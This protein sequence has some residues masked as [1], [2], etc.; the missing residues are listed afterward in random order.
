MKKLS[1][2]RL[3]EV[4]DLLADR[5]SCRNFS[6]EEIPEELLERL[7]QIGT[8]APSGGNLQSYTI[9]AVRDKEKKKL[10]SKALGQQKFVETAA[11]DFI[12]LLD[13]HKMSIYAKHCK[14]GYSQHKSLEFLLITVMDVICAAQSMETAGTLAGL[15]SCYVGNTCGEYDLLCEHFGMPKDK[16]F[17]LV[18]LSMGYPKHEQRARRKKLPREAVVGFESYPELSEERIIELFDEKY[19]SEETNLPKNE[20]SAE[21]MLSELKRCIAQSFSEE[22]TEE[23]IAGIRESGIV[24]YI[25]KK[26]TFQYDASGSEHDTSVMLEALHKAGLLEQ[27]TIE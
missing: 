4:Y 15:R 7:L 24:N 19:R 21:K 20:K 27:L 9:I 14:A 25:Q 18:T 22:E 6:D 16:V 17:P 8:A 26:F 5:Y 13:W 1:D 2:E 23:I 3:A 12:F 10:L 11:V